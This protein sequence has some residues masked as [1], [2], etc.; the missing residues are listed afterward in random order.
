[1]ND[2]RA[3]RALTDVV[4]VEQVAPG[5]AQ[6]VTWSDA[7][8]VDARD[9]GC[10]CPDKEYHDAPMCKHEYAALIADVDA[11]PDPYIECVSPRPVADGGERPEGCRCQDDAINS[12]ALAC[13]ACWRAGFETAANTET[14]A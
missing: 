13:F 9:A 11:Y 3:I 5:M 7:Y 4:A 2:E 12:D 8:V 6:V 10:R 14:N 1:M